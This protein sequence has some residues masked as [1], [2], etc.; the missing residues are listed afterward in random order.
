MEGFED[1]L[2][3]LLQTRE[4]RVMDCMDCHNRPTHR[5]HTPAEAVDLAMSQGKLDPSIPHLRR[6][7]VRAIQAEIGPRD[8]PAALIRD[9]LVE[10]YSKRGGIEE[11]M[12]SEQVDE[13]VPAL[14][15]IWGRNVFPAMKVDWNTYPSFLGHQDDGGCFRCHDGLHASADGRTISD[16]C[17]TCHLI[18]AE[19]EE[20][21][22]ILSELYLGTR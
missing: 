18:L 17:E 11:A 14:E 7:A 12:T 20:G 5:Y 9:A 13:V 15:A 21:P 10:A 19:D 16:D 6:S 4:K 8:D 2:E 22:A 1:E 3:E